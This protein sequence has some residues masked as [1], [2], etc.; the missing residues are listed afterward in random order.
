M[1]P[2]RQSESDIQRAI[3]EFLTAEGVLWWRCNLGGVRRSGKGWTPNPMKGF[4]DLAGILK[5]HG[6]FFAIEVK[7]V[8]ENPEPHQ[9]DWHRKLSACG[10]IVVVA[11]NVS[12]VR[13]AFEASTETRERVDGF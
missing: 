2:P 12:D 10:V 9:A 8:R 3:C 1:K 13:E 6:R 4:P 11:R 5:P 7:R